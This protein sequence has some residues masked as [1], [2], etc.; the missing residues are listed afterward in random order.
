[1]TEG[2][3]GEPVTDL[4][5]PSLLR[6][7]HHRIEAREQRSISQAEMASRLG[8]AHRTYVEYL[9]GTNT[10]KGIGVMYRLMQ[11][12]ADNDLEQVMLRYPSM[13]KRAST[14]QPEPKEY[15]E[16]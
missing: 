3:L 9:R 8:I 5:I 6:E 14:N 12:L 16:E 2:P 1:M 15:A 13:D 7:I 4:D 11:M 10:P